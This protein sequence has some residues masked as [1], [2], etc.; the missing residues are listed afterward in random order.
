MAEVVLFE[1]N[2]SIASLISLILA[3][4][5]HKLVAHETTRTA[6]INCLARL[7]TEKVHLDAILLDGNLASEND[8]TPATDPQAADVAC[9]SVN[10]SLRPA[11][12]VAIA[13][14]ME[15]Q[16]LNIP[17]IGISGRRLRPFIPHI[18]ADLPKPEFITSLDTVLKQLPG[19][20]FPE[21]I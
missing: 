17:I 11:D 10:D 18:Y 12:A 6:A 16:G 13:G 4:N 7:A 15:E 1:D 9:H 8:T 20:P 2:V 3:G 19:L 5:G 14:F 21:G